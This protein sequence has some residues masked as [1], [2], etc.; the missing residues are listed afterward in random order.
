MTAKPPVQCR[1]SRQMPVHRCP[2][3]PLALDLTSAKGQAGAPA[4]LAARA[5]LDLAPA[6]RPHEPFES[7]RPSRGGASACAMVNR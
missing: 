5:R 7:A 2:R 4:L 3:V 1:G 6:S